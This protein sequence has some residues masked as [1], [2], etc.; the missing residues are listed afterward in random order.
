VLRRVVL[1]VVSMLVAAGCGTSSG[2]RP[3]DRVDPAAA[4]AAAAPEDP[5]ADSPSAE[6]PNPR[7]EREPVPAGFEP[8]LLI[9]CE[10]EERTT[11]DDGEWTYRVEKRSTEGLDAVVAALRSPQPPPP[12]GN[13]ACRL[14]AYSDPWFLL[15]DADGR[16]VLPAVPHGACGEPVD[17]GLGHLDYTTA[18]TTKVRQQNTP[19]ELATGCSDQWKNEPRIF[20]D[21]GLEAATAPWRAATRPTAVCTYSSSGDVGTFTGGIR[22]DR[23]DADRLGDLL[24]GDAADAGDSCAAADDF[25]VVR[26]ADHG[27]VYVELSGCRR[28]V[29]E[30]RT[31][32]APVPDLVA[33]IR[34]LDLQR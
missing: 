24:R 18:S 28:L 26:T 33:A 13:Y 22:L 34:D 29:V 6:P 8:V 27:W 14:P 3:L 4:G 1:L 15:V 10:W 32:T 30:G 25:A 16:V 2:S 7:W 5:C 31:Y 23:Q 9:M 12:T 11:P 20:A 19:A 21:M 17:A